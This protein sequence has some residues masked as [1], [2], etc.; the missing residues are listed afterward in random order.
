MFA[1]YLFKVTYKNCVRLNGRHRGIVVNDSWFVKDLGPLQTFQGY[2][3]V[4]KLMLYIIQYTDTMGPVLRY[5]ILY[6]EFKACFFNNEHNNV[7]SI[8]P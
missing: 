3:G 2:D 5:R 4:R 7:Q 6:K 1:G 8:T